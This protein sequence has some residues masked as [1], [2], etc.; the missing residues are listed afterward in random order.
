MIKNIIVIVC[1]TPT[2]HQITLKNCINNDKKEK[3]KKLKDT[4]IKNMNN[5]IKTNNRIISINNIINKNILKI[6]MTN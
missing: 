3:R 6:R 1:I 4:E 2:N 5:K